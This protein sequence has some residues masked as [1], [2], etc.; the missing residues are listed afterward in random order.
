MAAVRSPAVGRCRAPFVEISVQ[1]LMLAVFAAAQTV[2][3]N[4]KPF[5]NDLTGKPVI[6]KLKWGMEYKGLRWPSTA[7]CLVTTHRP[8]GCKSLV[9]I[10]SDPEPTLPPNMND[11]WRRVPGLGGLLHEPAGKRWLRPGPTMRAG[12]SSKTCSYEKGPLYICAVCWWCSSRVQR[13]T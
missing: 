3:V 6:V 7:F 12:R 8:R 9:G 2:P 13:S 4:P 1:L 11:R 10:V 5:L